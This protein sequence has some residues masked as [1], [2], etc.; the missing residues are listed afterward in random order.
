LYVDLSGVQ[1]IESI[2]VDIGEGTEIGATRVMA[3]LGDLYIQQA[4]STSIGYHTI[5]L[6]L[7]FLPFD[8]L[9]ISGWETA[10]TGIRLVG[11]TLVDN[12]DI[13]FGSVKALY[14]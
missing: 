10:V 13:D 7:E 12:Q 5:T 4:T 14:R 11:A 2:Q 8:T 9:V 3:Y 6:P 1:G